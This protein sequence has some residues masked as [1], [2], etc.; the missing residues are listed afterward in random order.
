MRVLARVARRNF[1][2]R[3]APVLDRGLVGRLFFHRGSPIEDRFKMNELILKSSLRDSVVPGCVSFFRSV[4]RFDVFV[5]CG[6]RYSTSPG[7]NIYE[8]LNPSGG[9]RYVVDARFGP[10]V[11]LDKVV[12]GSV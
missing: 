7:V 2:D 10:V 8:E 9:T 5:I 11:G 6:N 3:D 1:R 4:R 12:Y